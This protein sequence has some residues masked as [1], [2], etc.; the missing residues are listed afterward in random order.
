MTERSLPSQFR[1]LAP[2]VADWALTNETDRLAKLIRTPLAELKAFYDAVFPLAE[3][4]KRY[5][6]PMKLDAMPAD[7]QTLLDL[8]LT[9]IE[10]AHP[11]ELSW[12]ETDIDDAFSL[13]RMSIRRFDVYPPS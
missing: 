5:L 13:E 12:T 1:D 8:L 10:T 6:M 11:I 7:A 2:F 9:F 4:I 3:E